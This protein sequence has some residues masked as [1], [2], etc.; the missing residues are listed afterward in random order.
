MEAISHQLFP[1]SRSFPESLL[2]VVSSARDCLQAG[3]SCT[4]DPSCSSKF[5]TLRQCIAGN[6]ANKLGP[7]AKSQCRNTVTA[8]LSSQL[9]GCKCKRGM[10]KEKQC[11][12]VYWSI[13]HTLMEGL[14]QTFRQGN[15]I[16]PL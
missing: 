12:S 11:L 16:G 6:G 13:H 9:Y 4:N 3:E 14:H 8:L 7:D 1:F 15:S 2:D 10:K 5:R